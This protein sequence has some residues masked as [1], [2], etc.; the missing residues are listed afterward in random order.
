MSQRTRTGSYDA[1]GKTNYTDTD[2]GS[3]CGDAVVAAM[4]ALSDHCGGDAE[5]MELDNGMVVMV[6]RDQKEM[7]SDL[8][9]EALTDEE[10]DDVLDDMEWLADWTT[11]LCQGAG[12]QSG[13]D[14]YTECRRRYVRQV[15]S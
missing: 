9:G 4:Q 1:D 7:L 5:P 15:L 6:P 8:D 12:L 3:A 2:E 14:G 11:E 13:T 10:V